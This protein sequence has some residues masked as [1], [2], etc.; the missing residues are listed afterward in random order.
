[1]SILAKNLVTIRKE[2]RCT[3]SA[4]AEIL[5]VG[6]RTYVRYEAGER[7]APVSV[8]V[9]VAKL[10]NMSLELMLT[11]EVGAEDIVPLQAIDFQAPPPE[12]K[13]CDFRTGQIEF[14]KPSVRGLLVSDE[15]ERK[16]VGFFRKM[17]LATQKACLDSVKKAGKGSKGKGEPKKIVKADKPKKVAVRREPSVMVQ[18]KAPQVR[19]KGKPGRRKLDKKVLK[20]KIDK[21]KM[22]TKS[23]NKIT[24]R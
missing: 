18:V 21:L 20:E 22:L 4:M 7:D 9:K 24:V 13:K 1:M 8:L 16:L 5:K 15:R 2:L 12:V 19:R 3:Q 6:F 10:A 14:K 17:D 11:T 23:I